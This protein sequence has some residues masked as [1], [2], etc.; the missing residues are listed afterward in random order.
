MATAGDAQA[1][2]DKAKCYECKIPAG[3]APYAALA[4]ALDKANGQPVPSDPDELL[5]EVTCLECVITEGM[6]PYALTQAIGQ[7]P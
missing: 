6:V 4:A 3:K 7:I 2:I 5:A 1:L